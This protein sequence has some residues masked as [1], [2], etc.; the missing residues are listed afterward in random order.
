MAGVA[1]L[2]DGLVLI[3]DLETF[4][5]DAEAAALDDAMTAQ[6]ATEAGT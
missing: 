6:D 5:S 2:R 4:L 1:K 3:H